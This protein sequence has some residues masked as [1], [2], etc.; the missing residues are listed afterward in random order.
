MLVGFYKKR[1][2]NTITSISVH[3][4]TIILAIAIV[5]S[6]LFKQAIYSYDY[7]LLIAL[8]DYINSSRLIMKLYLAVLLILGIGFAIASAA[9]MSDAELKV[10]ISS[11]VEKVVYC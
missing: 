10:M 3:W 8:Q 11:A 2:S 4:I 5:P 7:L 9:P 1:V 6:Y